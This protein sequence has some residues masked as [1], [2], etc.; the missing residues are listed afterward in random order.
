MALVGSYGSKQFVV[1]RRR[2]YTVSDINL[3]SSIEFEDKE[4]GKGVPIKRK[5][6]EN[7]EE[8]T[9]N[10]KLIAQCCNV[11]DEF[12]SWKKMKSA[13]VPYYF[14]LG[15]RKLSTYKLVITNVS[16]A[17]IHMAAK[18]GVIS[19]ATM[20][21][22]FVESGSKSQPLLSKQASEEN[23][24]LA[25]KSTRHC[26]MVKKRIGKSTKWKEMSECFNGLSD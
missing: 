25:A 3:S 15:S 19:S 7:G 5:K 8:L 2:I 10:I 26:K 23:R 9:I 4:N 6:K 22:T 12:E 14:L 11:M 20:A 18:K 17:D 1:S 21:V 13:A 16:L 24:Q